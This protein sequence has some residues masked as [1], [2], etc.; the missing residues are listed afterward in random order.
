MD[1]NGIGYG[2]HISFFTYQSLGEEGDEV[3]LHTYTH[4]REDVLALYG[5]FSKD[6]RTLFKTLISVTGIGARMAI[7]ILSHIQ[8]DE[9]R[10]AVQQNAVEK[11]VAI[12]KIG[13]KTAQRLVL[14]FKEK[15]SGFEQIPAGTGD[16]VNETLEV[17]NDCVS[18]LINLGYDKNAAKKIVQKVSLKKPKESWDIVSLIS[19]CLQS[20][21]DKD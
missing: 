6:E 7:N 21:R 3:L 16:T 1:V 8:P 10:M 2:V 4:V 18:A 13:L 19:S 20:I 5:F 15:W 11:L 9:F 14:E 17:M 12:P